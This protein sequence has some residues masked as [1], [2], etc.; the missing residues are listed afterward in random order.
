MWLVKVET[1]KD[2][3]EISTQRIDFLLHVGRELIFYGEPNVKETILVLEI[4][5][6]GRGRS[7]MQHLDFHLEK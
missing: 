3:M 6:G 5:I 2:D 1:R 7:L 4:S